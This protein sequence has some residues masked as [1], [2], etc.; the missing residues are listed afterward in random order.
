[1]R[2]VFSDDGFRDL[3]VLGSQRERDGRVIVGRVAVLHTIQYKQVRVNQLMM[4]ERK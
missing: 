1:M 3:L 4:R 2:W